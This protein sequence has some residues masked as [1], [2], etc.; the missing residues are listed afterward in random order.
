MQKINCIFVEEMMIQYIVGIKSM[1]MMNKSYI[2][3]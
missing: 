1:N 3:N 2:Y